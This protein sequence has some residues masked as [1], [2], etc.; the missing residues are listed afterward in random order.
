LW[1]NW[2][3]IEDTCGEIGENLK[4]FCVEIGEKMKLFRGEIDKVQ[5]ITAVLLTTNF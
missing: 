3:E 5:L 1:W 4:D 2:W